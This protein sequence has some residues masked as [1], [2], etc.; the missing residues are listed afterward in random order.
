MSTTQQDTIRSSQAASVHSAHNSTP[1]GRAATV[2]SVVIGQADTTGKSS[3]SGPTV[4]KNR[5]GLV[6]RR[7]Y[8]LDVLSARSAL[9]EHYRAFDLLRRK[10][11]SIKL[12]RLDSGLEKLAD[13]RLRH[14]AGILA[15]LSHPNV[16][17]AKE[18]NI[19]ESGISY[20]VIESLEG[21]TL[22]QLLESN[23]RLPLSEAKEIL[24]GIC[25]GLARAHEIGVMHGDLRPSCIFLQKQPKGLS[26]SGATGKLESRECVKLLDFE[27]ASELGSCGD[28]VADTIPPYVLMGS[29]PYR[30]P[31]ALT[32]DARG[33]SPRS[34]LWSVAVIA[35]QMLSGRLPFA[36]EDTRKLSEQ[37]SFS[38]PEPL[39]QLVSDL[40]PSVADAIMTALSKS[41]CLRFASVA[42]FLRA[43]DG[44][45]GQSDPALRYKGRPTGLHEV[46]PRLLAECRLAETPSAGVPVMIVDEHS[47]RRYPRADYPR[48]LL[49]EQSER[50]TVSE[51]FSMQPRPLVMSE[52]GSSTGRLLILGLALLSI[53]FSGVFGIGFVI[54]QKLRPATETSDQSACAGQSES[55]QIDDSQLTEESSLLVQEVSG[56]EEPAPRDLWVGVAPPPIER[57]VIRPPAA[58][59]NPAP[60]PTAPLRR[61]KAVESESGIDVES[62]PP[63]AD[64]PPF[65][66]RQNEESQN[67]QPAPASEPKTNVSLSVQIME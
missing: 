9:G 59:P 34:D 12:A 28:E 55:E 29:L 8:R 5:C 38:D 50:T 43:L 2:G 1:S 32:G 13:E 11:C 61:A 22:A 48:T 51:Q 46:E 40:P 47:T 24:R 23:G 67:A 26:H 54:A 41:R 21:R 19:D 52:Q 65:A 20:L 27:L 14:E 7:R 33:L 63:P 16:V 10:S 15:R 30:A 37:I 4:N 57:S 35:Y 45:S 49:K 39:T 58:Q 60:R 66:N 42:E 53:L 31:E 44:K 56:E 62:L 6:L 3:G 17:E 18:L 36:E 25:S 64:G